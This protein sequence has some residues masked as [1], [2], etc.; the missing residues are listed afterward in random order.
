VWDVKTKSGEPLARLLERDLLE[1]LQSLGFEIALSKPFKK[2]L[3]V[4]IKDWNFDTYINGK[5]WY[6]LMITVLDRENHILA[7]SQLKDRVV[8]KGS[9]WV[10]AK[11][12]F[13]KELPKIYSQ[14]ITK[15]V[16]ENPKILTALQE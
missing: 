5:F 14:I 13:E 8:V 9:V 16:R 12:A 6:H 2:T 4:S 1:E 3:Q 7:E 15:I 11:Y 10:G